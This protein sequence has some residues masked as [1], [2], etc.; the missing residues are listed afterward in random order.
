DTLPFILSINGMPLYLA[1]FLIFHV[2]KP[3]NILLWASFYCWDVI[4]LLYLLLSGMV[5]HPIVYP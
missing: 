1:M 4:R 5:R 2:T 3:L